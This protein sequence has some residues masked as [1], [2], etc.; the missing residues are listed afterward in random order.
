M[1]KALIYLT[2]SV[3]ILGMIISYDIIKYDGQVLVKNLIK[4]KNE[5]VLEQAYEY[6]PVEKNEVTTDGGRDFFG[7]SELKVMEAEFEDGEDIDDS[8][9]EQVL[10]DFSEEDS[11]RGYEYYFDLLNSE[12]KKIY[13]A[14]YEAFSN[15]ESGNAIPTVN[16]ESMNRVAGYIRLDHPEFFYAKDL[17]Y[18]HYTMGGQVVKTVL[19][20]S[21]T[22][23]KA[24]IKSQMDYIDRMADELI[25]S[26]PADA[27]DYTKAK[28]VYEWIILNTDYSS[29]APENQAMTSVFL[30]HRSVCAG[31][32]RAFQYIM[33]RMGVDTTV[34]EGNSLISGENHAWNMCKLSDG[35]YYVD[36][37]WGDASYQ[38]NGLSGEKVMGMNYDYLLVTTDEIKRTHKITLE[39]KLP[40]CDRTENNYYV[41]EGLFFMDYD[42]DRLM[43]I[44]NDAYLKGESVVAF[45]C[46]N[47][48]VYDV[49]RRELISN[50]GVF[51]MLG[52][53]AATISYVED[54]AQRTLCF[55]L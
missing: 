37:T 51:D 54:E 22:E 40:L 23:S 30:N 41:R 28:T 35:Y 13:R 21:Y 39:D 2:F 36:A 16:E 20:V 18:T 44:F 4:P 25:A 19:A 32:S 17:G 14:M 45:K 42:H 24:S 27:D 7:D 47:L 46:A 11:N 50:N 55:W 10:D 33:N 1:K 12:E 26:I 48:E 38:Q 52:S 29:D 6:V 49:M 3:F 53:S 43:Q 9:D 5:P 8:Y 31:Y 34:I 15:I